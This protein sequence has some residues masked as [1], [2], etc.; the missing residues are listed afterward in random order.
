MEIEVLDKLVEE[1]F[2]L[3]KEYKA[4]DK[5]SKGLFAELKGKQAGI[6]EI[7]KDLGKT[8]YST[9]IGTVGWTKE[10][11]FPKP[12]T[13]EER[14]QMIGY[15]KKQGVY[16]DMMDV[17]AS[18]FNAFAK[19]EEAASKELDFQMPGSRKS[20]REKISMVKAR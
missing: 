3:N 4:A 5:I 1:V 9:D 16:E 17:N 15:L 20:S 10:S 14:A 11:Y 2:E 6:A 19:Q 7:L 18:R 13:P 8:K 12:V